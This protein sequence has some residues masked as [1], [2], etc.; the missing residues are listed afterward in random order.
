MELSAAGI[1]QE[2]TIQ[3]VTKVKDRLEK[4]GGTKRKS[5][6][7]LYALAEGLPTNSYILSRIRLNDVGDIN[8]YLAHV[9]SQL[10]EG[11]HFIGCAD[12]LQGYRTKIFSKKGLRSFFSLRMGGF[13]FHRVLPKFTLTASLY[14]WL[15]KDRDK[16]LS[17]TE[18]L[19][20]IAYAGFKIEKVT[21]EGDI[22]HFKARKNSAPLEGHSPTFGPLIKLNRLVKNGRM[23]KIYKLRTMHPYAEFIQDY[24]FEQNDLDV[25]GKLKDDFRVSEEGTLFRKMFLDELP[26]LINLLKGDIKLVGVRPLSPH[27]FS[28]Y[29]E[30]MQRRRIKHT[31]GLLPPYYSEAVKPST[32]EEV[33]VSEMR[34]LI[35]HEKHPFRTDVKYFFRILNNIVLKR[36]RSK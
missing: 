31:P 35:Q 23:V 22:L 36:V 28:L 17:K 16:R 34:Y 9:N 29:T 20:R 1:S 32:L 5:I 19:G 7:Q 21:K 33:M 6:M 10:S 11:N 25:G 24:V 12:Y 8:T 2:G 18:I 14:N 27:Y 3:F 26:M 13:I 4:N 30:A 15:M